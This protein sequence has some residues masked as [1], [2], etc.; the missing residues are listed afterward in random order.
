MKF[1]ADVPDKYYDLAIV[2]PPYGINEHGQRM[3]RTERWKNPKP[4]KYKRV[5]WDKQA[6]PPEYFDLLNRKAKNMIIWGANHFLDNIPFDISSPCWIVWDKKTAGDFADCELAWTSFNTAVRKFEY[7]WSG[8]R[9]QQPED[10]I[11][12]TQKPVALYEW[13]LS[14]YAKPNDKIID[15]HGGSGSIAIAVDKA[16]TLD[17]TNYLLDIIE[18]DKDYFDA[19]LNRFNK[20]KSQQTI[21]FK[22]HEHNSRTNPN[23]AHS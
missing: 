18:L 17:N 15:T 23:Q 6:P 19:S 4:I 10:R 13:L 12:P 16:N 1:M 20:Y 8:F 7:L 21:Q 9:K 5:Q 14:K 11:H 3:N 2:D 22:Q